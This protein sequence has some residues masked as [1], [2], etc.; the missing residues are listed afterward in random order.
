MIMSSKSETGH[1][2]NVANF[3]ELISFVRGYG[4]SL[5]PIEQCYC[6][7]HAANSGK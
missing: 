2:V 4:E 1:A 3:N 6:F 7:K 5:Q